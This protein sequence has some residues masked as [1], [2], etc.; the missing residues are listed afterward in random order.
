MNSGRL[1]MVD[2]NTFFNSPLINSIFSVPKA[3]KCFSAMLAMASFPSIVRTWHTPAVLDKYR[4]LRPRLV[5]VSNRVEALRKTINR[6]RNRE[7]RAGVGEVLASLPRVVV[8]CVA[9]L[10]SIWRMGCV[11]LRSFLRRFSNSGSG[12]D[13]FRSTWLYRLKTNGECSC[14]APLD[15]MACEKYC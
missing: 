7:N 4:V 13:F 5:P 1:W 11:D 12:I 14:P 15:L 3:R 8:H 6:L 10:K 9:R 2:A